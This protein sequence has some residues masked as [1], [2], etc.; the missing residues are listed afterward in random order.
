MATSIKE[1]GNVFGWTLNYSKI[2][3][4]LVKGVDSLKPVSEGSNEK[5]LYFHLQLEKIPH[6]S[7][8]INLHSFCNIYWGTS[9]VPATV[10]ST[11]CQWLPCSHVSG[12]GRP[13]VQWYT[14]YSLQ[15]V[16]DFTI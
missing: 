3:L 7:V 4:A 5:Y 12:I 11:A 2:L 10:I 9:S 13:H 8:H 15:C 16:V 14:P 1:T 6:A